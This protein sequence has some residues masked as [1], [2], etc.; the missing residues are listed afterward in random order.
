M[1]AVKS[2][3]K[4]RQGV[5]TLLLAAGI[6]LRIEYL[7]E[8]A[9]SPLFAFALGADVSEYWE[10]A[11]AFLN[12]S[13]KVAPP[14]IH[15]PLYSLFLA[16]ESLLTGGSIPVIR[17][18]QLFLGVL[19]WCGLYFFLRKHHCPPA[20]SVPE[21]VFAC[22]MLYTPL[23]FFQAELVSESLLLL[24][25]P[26]I[27]CSMTALAE[28]Q[29]DD[30]KSMGL[31]AAG[32]LLTGLAIITHPMT[33]LYWGLQSLVLLLNKPR[34]R[35]GIYLAA[36]LLVLLPVS[37]AR[38]IEAGRPVLVQSNS[39]FNLYLGNNAGA[40][41]TCYLRPGAEWKKLH[42][43]A[44]TEAEMRNC[45]QDRIHLE[46]TWNFI[47]TSPLQ[48]AALLLKKALLVWAP[49]ELPS[50]ADAPPVFGWTP[51]IRLTAPFLQVILLALAAA[52]LYP[53][54]RNPEKR[55]R[56][57]PFLLMTA[58]FYA[59]QIIFVT[60]GRYRL[61]M[62]PGLFV[63]AANFLQWR[64]R[65]YGDKLLAAGGAALL[66]GMAA[67]T[68][69]TING[70]AESR[71]LFAEALFRQGRPEA[72]KFLLSG[73]TGDSNDPARDMNML[74]MTEAQTGNRQEA[75]RLFQKAAE[76]APHEAEGLMNLAILHS[77][78]GELVKA[79]S[80]LRQA[81]KRE[82]DHP[83]TL[84]NL[85]LVLEKMK[86]YPEAAEHLQILAVRTPADTKVLNALGRVSFLQGDLD[87]AELCFLRA[88]ELNPNNRGIQKNL[89]IVRRQQKAR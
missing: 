19:A 87:L 51:L 62:L 11:Q 70:L 33:L 24:L 15:A 64:P 36:G 5:F 32:G 14:D 9:G 83:G 86:R 42:R 76:I 43:Q 72:V 2:F 38:S 60:S 37:I 80:L 4:S 82:W 18:L 79:E 46:H 49:G 44:R 23:I 35:A 29:E 69:P 56:W 54:L 26:P 40:D 81:Q 57:M 7:R 50:G 67:F 3:F 61:A 45:P 59:G 53:V 65:R 28:R 30:L 17:G 47:R 71:T 74:G 1:I 8:F 39:A 78:A 73:R 12:G 52:G 16:L 63:L 68:A 66:V 55:Q 25:L 20:S 41:G 75:A 13:W 6:L 84:Y 89:D 77:E 58:A 48:E 21:W 27:L 10:R 85:A 34:L 88:L 31:A 22:G